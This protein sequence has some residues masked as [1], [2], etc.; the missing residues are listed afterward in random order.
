MGP[1]LHDLKHILD[2]YGVPMDHMLCLH[3]SPSTCLIAYSNAKWGAYVYPM[4]YI[5]LLYTFKEKLVSW[6]S[7]C[8][9][10][11]SCLSGEDKYQVLTNVVAK[12]CWVCNILCELC[13]LPSKVTLV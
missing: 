10:V 7:K 2:A 4:I 12:T 5:R 13:P 9:G 8:Q 6:S 11:I 1:Y 3:A